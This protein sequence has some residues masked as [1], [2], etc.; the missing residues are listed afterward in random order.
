MSITARLQKVTQGLSPLQRALLVLQALREGKEPD[1]E[2]RRI[3]DEQQRRAF[4]RYMGLLWVIK[5]QLGAVLSIIQSRVETA[6][7]HLHYF[8][9]FNQAAALVEEQ[10]GVKPA[11][12]HRKW[13][14]QKGEIT[15]PAFLRS[16][17]LEARDD[18]SAQL[19]HLWQELQAFEQ[20]VDD[21]ASDFAGEDPLLPDLRER[22]ADI[23]SRL[24]SAATRLGAGKL[25]DTP[26][27]AFVEAYAAT[28]D[29][30]FKHLNLVEH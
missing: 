15:V 14:Q 21:L 22:A 19:R 30:A 25:P 10:E 12:G 16:L 11:R 8:E 20:V 6:E 1:P 27:P 23:R 29:E 7:N 5:H 17:A 18:G 9:L 24:L 4:N 3:D 26:D 28:V 13:R 2:L